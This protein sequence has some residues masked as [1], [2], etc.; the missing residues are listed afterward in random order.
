MVSLSN[1]VRKKVYNPKTSLLLF[2][3]QSSINEEISSLESSACNT[4]DTSSIMKLAKR[5]WYNKRNIT[6]KDVIFKEF[7]KDM[8]RLSTSGEIRDALG[9]H[10][11]RLL[12]TVVYYSRT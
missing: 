11:S 12:L 7:K 3:L 5:S 8:D 1:N 9:Q 10:H 6:V 2:L 4:F